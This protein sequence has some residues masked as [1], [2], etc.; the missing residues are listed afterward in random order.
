MITD[1][2]ATPFQDLEKNGV[3][4]LPWINGM[5]EGVGYDSLT[6]VV[7]GDASGDGSDLTL[8]AVTEAQAFTQQIRRIENTE[9]LNH[10]L[11]VSASVSGGYAAFSASASASYLTESQVNSY[12]LFFLIN[13]VVRNSE[14]M[15]KRFL[16]DR[17]TLGLPADEFRSK[18]GD[19]FVQG[20]VAGGTFYSLLQLE[21][22]SEQTKEDISVSVEAKYDAGFSIGAKFSTDIK[23]AASHKGVNFSEQ[24]Q[25]LGATPAWNATAKFDTPEDILEAAQSFPAAVGQAGD[26]MFAILMPY[27]LL[28]DAPQSNST[29]DMGALNAVRQSLLDIYVQAKQ[30]LD[31]V[32]YALEHPRQFSSDALA[33][34][35]KVR[36][37]LMAT[38]QQIE[39]ANAQL[40]SDPTAAIKLPPPVDLSLIPQRL[41]GGTLT[42]IAPPPGVVPDTL[43]FKIGVARREAWSMANADLKEKVASYLDKIEG[44]VTSNFGNAVDFITSLQSSI[45]ALDNAIEYDAALSIVSSLANARDTSA[46]AWDAALAEQ[47]AQY[48]TFSSLN[49]A[50]ELDFLEK[51]LHPV[52][53]GDTDGQYGGSA[54]WRE[55]QK[56]TDGLTTI[57]NAWGRPRGSGVDYYSF[58]RGLWEQLRQQFRNAALTLYNAG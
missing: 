24:H 44:D 37:D 11:A 33:N 17:E 50:H 28:K 18:F 2:N 43:R 22:D 26:P 14:K 32:N 9:Q 23:N 48:E 55:L 45:R 53:W 42:V 20:I 40:R 8:T 4:V 31:S 58:K 54:F 39:A 36:N 38:M 7:K 52:V 49:T 3:I 57:A 46:A 41:W 30:V 15:V 27:A 10:S 35:G 47:R 21:T 13:T 1:T 6:Q 19:Y 29:I 25:A 16:L 5:R 12:S 34:L 51:Y 56:T